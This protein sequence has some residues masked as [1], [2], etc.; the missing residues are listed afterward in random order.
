MAIE[1]YSYKKLPPL[2]SPLKRLTPKEETTQTTS[3]TQTTQDKIVT[4]RLS[5]E[6]YD[7]LK[8]LGEHKKF[9]V[10]VKE[11]LELWENEVSK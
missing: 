9:S 4:F 8:V 10:I 3:T 2:F 5:Q 1:F 11:G 6:W 7:K